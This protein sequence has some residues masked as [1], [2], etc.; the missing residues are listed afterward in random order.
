MTK[1]GNV[2]S[3]AISIVLGLMLLIMK[4]DVISIALTILGI[5]VIISA[6]VD[7]KNKMTNSAIIKAVIGVCILLF[8]WLFVN[9]ALYILAAAIIIS[10]LLQISDISKLSPV[11]LP[12]KEKALLYL[13]PVLTVLAG[14]C[15]LFNQGGTIAWV[16]TATGILL[17]AEGILDLVH[18]AKK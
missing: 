4:D 12:A 10:G 18:S 5:A 6:I 11:N 14:A 3:A 15:L 8:G 1:K 13:K 16:F 9:L 7:F 17:I 2:F